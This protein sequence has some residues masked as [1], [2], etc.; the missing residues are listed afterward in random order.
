MS[1]NYKIN[2]ERGSTKVFTA[3]HKDAN[4]DV[5][6]LTGYDARMYFKEKINSSQPTLSLYSSAS[7][8]NNSQLVMTP[9]SGS[10]LVYISAADTE[11]L[12]NSVYFY[13]LEIYTAEDPYS[14]ND[15]EYVVR[16]L[17]GTAMVKYNI[18]D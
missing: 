11:L 13:D 17:E 14:Q 10:I 5:I 18:T 12:T 1:K 4:G 2:L 8:S 15:L 3:V 9:T 7:T 6:D 16:L